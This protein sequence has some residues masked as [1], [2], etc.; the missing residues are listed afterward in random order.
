MRSPVIVGM[1]WRE[2][3]ARM[4]AKFVSFREAAMSEAVELARVHAESKRQEA[5]EAISELYTTNG[6]WAART[7]LSGESLLLVRTRSEA[8]RDSRV[9]YR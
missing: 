1:A 2:Y 5:L 6:L 8:E 7:D 9:L 3:N 4:N